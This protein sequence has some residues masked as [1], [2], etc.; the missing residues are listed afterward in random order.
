MKLLINL[1]YQ[2]LRAYWFIARPVTL[3]VRILMLHNG[4]TLLVRH[5]YQDAWFM[6]GGGVKRGETLEQAARR[7][8]WEECGAQLNHLVLL[9][10][11]TNFWE[12]KS[13]HVVMFLCDDFSL[14]EKSD[15]EIAEVAFFDPDHLPASAS[16]STRQVIDA[17][18][19]GTLEA[20]GL[21]S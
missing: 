19:S 18:R 14:A 7:E 9:G 6:P 10:V 4:Q 8:S 20:F 1:A 15:P 2:A 5:V 17:Y 16:G 21:W 3:G 12:Y 13:D 11:Y